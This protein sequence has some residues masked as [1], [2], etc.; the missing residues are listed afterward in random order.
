MGTQSPQSLGGIA[1]AEKIRN[2]YIDS[3]NLCANCGE[4]ILPVVGMSLPAVKKK[5]F[6]NKS[7]AAKLNNRLFPKKPKRPRKFNECQA[8]S[9][10]IDPPSMTCFSCVK[11]R[12]AQMKKADISRSEIGQHARRVL[13]KD[14]MECSVCG[15][16]AHVEACH[17]RP[18][19]DFPQDATVGEIN[20]RSNLMYL[21][22]N[23]H[24]E[25]DH[26]M[27][28]VEVTG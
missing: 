11:E 14:S 26:G 16:S 5:R 6:C 28:T 10:K 23:H 8:C 13:G 19:S 27:I 7:C 9:V 24:W 4:P 22:P 2:A 1:K 12:T 18:V 17:I 15:Y 3:P 21:C 25:F 20:D